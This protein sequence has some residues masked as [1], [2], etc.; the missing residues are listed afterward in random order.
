MHD[1]VVVDYPFNRQGAAEALTITSLGR[2]LRSTYDHGDRTICIAA[3]QQRV[4]L[5]MCFQSFPNSPGEGSK[6]QSILSARQEPQI[7][8]T[9]FIATVGVGGE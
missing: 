9:L 3:D 5:L 7:H 6:T 1:V 2:S 8:S 4:Q